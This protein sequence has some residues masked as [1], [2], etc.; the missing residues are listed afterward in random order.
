MVRLANIRT[1]PQLW[2]HAVQHH[3]ESECLVFEDA[4]GR[5]SRA[6]YEQFWHQICQAAGLLR[7]LGVGQGDYVVIQL[8]NSPELLACQF[9][10]NLLGAVAVPLHPQMSMP[11]V[12]HVITRTRA[13]L[14]ICGADLAAQAPVRGSAPA[15]L[16]AGVDAVPSPGTHSLALGM[17]RQSGAVLDLPVVDGA[18]PALVLFTAG[19]TAQ[20]KAAVMTH[21]DLTFAGRFVDWQVNLASTDR[22]VTA[23]P[24][25]HVVFQL[26]ACLP[27]LMAGAG[28]VLLGKTHPSRFWGRVKSHGGTVV[29]ATST[30]IR[31]LL[32]QPYSD[33]DA[34][35]RVREVLYY[36]QLSDEDKVEFERRF[37]VILSTAYGTTES[38]VGAITDPPTGERRWQSVG[39]VAPPY[40]A[41]VVGPDGREVADGQQ[42]EIQLRGVPGETLM[43]AYL[44]DPVTT[45][46]LYTADGWMHTG[47]LGHRSVDGWYY[48]YDRISRLIRRSGKNVSPAEVEAVLVSHPGI[49]EAVVY[50]VPDPVHGQAIGAAVAVNGSSAL[51]R[52][53]VGAYCR[54]YLA[55][56]K[57]PSRISIVAALPRT[58][59]DQVD[60][61]QL[62]A[63]GMSG[64][65]P[66]LASHLSS[67]G[68]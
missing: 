4:S 15:V 20:P 16:V 14:V 34:R 63:I 35:H 39:Q 61:G 5:V 18:D 62:Q 22:L 53:D 19:T 31:S 6:T 27:A 21:A 48:F 9:G 10:A 36:L 12:V 44:D 54:Q 30:V 66:G 67:A 51:D 42:G 7:Q 59:T 17:A 57:V 40:E 1:L 3:S 65:Q 56:F 46:A 32:A 8:A 11:E 64:A 23:M 13:H 29:Q 28:L 41:R 50:A 33:Q 45:A 52:R 68:A 26:N 49:S 25:S 2:E 43:Q 60:I 24:A 47:D 55:P 37:A 58:G 38:L